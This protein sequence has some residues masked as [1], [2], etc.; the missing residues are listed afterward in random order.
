MNETT[1]MEAMETSMEATGTNETTTP[2]TDPDDWDSI[3]FSDLTDD[4]APPPAAA[5]EPTQEEPQP[6]ADQQDGGEET[7]PQEGADKP[8]SGK[9]A[10]QEAPELFELKHLGEVHQVNRDQ[11]V[12]LAQK[13]MDYDHI[14]GERDI[15]RGKAFELENFLR[16]LAE[17]QGISIED[18]MDQTR[19]SVLADRE[20]L[21]PSVALQRVKLERDRRSFETQRQMAEQSQQARAQEDARIQQSFLRFIDAYPEVDPKDIP[22]E[23]W[24]EFGTGRDLTDIYARF[25]N[26][27]LKDQLKT[28]LEKQQVLEQNNKNE[29]RS[30]GSQQSAGMSAAQK[31]DPIDEDWYSGD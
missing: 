9:D 28:A 22:K 30:T 23:V 12:V 1:N 14:R 21:E 5:Q 20:G 11:M 18:L 31:R 15:A 29:E 2:E 26:K 19:A 4:A 16:E 25:E 6:E 13:G 7:E 10:E 17:P 8:E 24:D 3:D 27:Q